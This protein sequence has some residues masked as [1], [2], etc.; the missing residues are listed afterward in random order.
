MSRSPQR[1]AWFVSPHGFG[2]AARSAAVIG[3][4]A[5]RVPALAPTLLTTVPRWFFAESIA[6]EFDYGEL[7]C[8]VGFVQQSAVEED[9]EA[10]VARLEALWDGSGGVRDRVPELLRE[11]GATAVVADVAP[12]GLVAARAAGLPSVLIE[13]FTWDW[14][15]AGVVDRQPRLEPWV[16]RMRAAFLL[17]DL[18][19]Q[20]EPVCAPAASAI[21]LPPIARRPR[22]ARAE[23]RARLGIAP[24]R[25]MVLVSMGGIETA[26]GEI[27]RWRRLAGV[28]FVVP[29]GAGREERRDNL[30][31]LPHHTPIFH[32][33]LVAAA[34]VVAGKL[35]YST[36]AETVAAGGRY[37]FVPRP[38]FR[39]S[40]V[41]ADYVRSRLPAIELDAGDFDSGRWVERLPDLLARPRAAPAAADGAG[42]AAD[43]IVAAGILGT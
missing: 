27:D 3:A 8:D 23:V 30:V 20:A 28:D 24:G 2:H 35:G 26:H 31:L 4:L 19:L 6:A 32:P 34:D 38:G 10:T 42:V 15:Y 5:E 41:L 1:V 12:L 43:A 29:G 16:A 25:P 36:V 9:L 37:A 22:T 33:D 40:A 21:A 14:I 18:R 11:L 13:N 7:D 17:A 39:E